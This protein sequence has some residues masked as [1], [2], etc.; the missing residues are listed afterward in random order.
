MILRKPYAFLIKHFKFIHLFLVLILSF[1]C[2]RSYVLYNFLESYMDNPSVVTG[3]IDLS[4]EYIGVFL[5]LAIVF[6]LFLAFIIIVLL[7]EKDKP[8]K[9]YIFVFCYYLALFIGLVYISSVL[10]TIRFSSVET[11]IIKTITDVFFVTYLIQY[12]LI[13][14][15]LTRAVGFNV[16]K[17]DFQ[18]DLLEFELSEFDDEEFE[19]NLGVDT[20]EYSAKARYNLRNFRYLYRENKILFV[21]AFIGIVL[22]VGLVIINNMSKKEVIYKENETF[23]TSSY[24]ITVLNS[25][26]LDED[27]QGFEIKK[28]KFYIVL[29][30]KFRNITNEKLVLNIDNT[31]V[32]FGDDVSFIPDR[33]NYSSFIEF[34]RPY[35]GQSFLP[36]EEKEFI[37]VYEAPKEYKNRDFRFGYLIGYTMNDSLKEMIYKKVDLKPKKFIGEEKII[38]DVKLNEPLVF[39]DSIFEETSLTIHSIDFSQSYLYKYHHCINTVCSD[40]NN[41]L[42]TSGKYNYGTTLMRIEYDL[43]FNSM[44]NS[45]INSFIS[46]F[47]KISYVVGDREVFSENTIFKDITPINIKGYSYFEVIDRLEKADK[48]Y[49]NFSVRGKKY[50]YLI[51]D[52]TQEEDKTE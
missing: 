32:Y 45:D 28:D 38:A 17:F 14:F 33:M 43:E 47:A 51:F 13:V 8:R 4:K 21:F 52:N 31:K 46:S 37:L 35:Y 5:Y 1:V 26:Q 16:K 40:T 41:F 7:K 29:Q 42:I 15:A 20:E 22:I 12:L 39:K 24:A 10:D 49:L 34:G 6:V 19:L 18:K 36:G 30:V 25:Y 9:Y 2:Y 27:Y 3:F 44:Y 50:R 11:R 48:I 23:S